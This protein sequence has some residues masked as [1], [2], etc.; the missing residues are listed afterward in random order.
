MPDWRAVARMDLST[1]VLGILLFVLSLA[2]PYYGASARGFNVSASINAWH[3]WNVL[4]LLL[5]LVATLVI[6]VQVFADTTLP[7]LP[8]G[9]RWVAAG[10]A[11]LGLLIF[12]IRTFTLPHGDAGLGVSYGLRWGA[13]VDLILFV[14]F[15]GAAVLAAREGDG[16]NPMQ[17][18]TTTTAPPA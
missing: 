12:I 4:A 6:A 3:S 7:S 8:V 1:L 9:Y 15:T 16:L 17:R 18:P 2:L 10:L 13:W 11:A 5:A 14:L